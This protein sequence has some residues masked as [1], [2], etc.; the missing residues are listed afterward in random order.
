MSLSHYERNGFNDKKLTINKSAA[1]SF[2]GMNLVLNQ[3]KVIKYGNEI[4]RSINGLFYL[5]LIVFNF[6]YEIE[7]SDY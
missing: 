2:T 3:L 5:S 4:S 7:K 1:G 6:T